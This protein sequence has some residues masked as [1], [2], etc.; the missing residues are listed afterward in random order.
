[1]IATSRDTTKAHQKFIRFTWNE[2]LLWLILALK[3][4]IVELLTSLFNIV[5]P[6]SS[7]MILVFPL[8]KTFGTAFKNTAQFGRSGDIKFLK[9]KQSRRNSRCRE[10][11]TMQVL[12]LIALLIAFTSA[13]SV[14]G[15]TGM[16]RTRMQ[17][18][19]AALS[20]AGCAVA[21]RII[22]GRDTPRSTA[23]S[24]Y[25]LHT[26]RMDSVPPVVIWNRDNLILYTLFFERQ[27]VISTWNFSYC[28]MT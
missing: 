13:L 6:H 17:K 2:S 15:S 7:S 20:K 26:I 21:G 22:S 3:R 11:L 14:T 18:Y 27:R 10:R 4:S 24:R 25:A 16:V 12:P 8:K 5:F 19:L 28:K 23:R 1:M 9:I